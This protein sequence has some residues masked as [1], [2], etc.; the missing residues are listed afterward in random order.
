MSI[1]CS[2]RAIIT[3]SCLDYKK[4]CQLE[5][6]KYVHSLEEHRNGMTP[7]T[8]GAIALRP[9]GNAQGYMFFYSI[10]TGKRINRYKWMALP[11]PNHVVN[12]VEQLA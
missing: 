4:H 1:A 11:M 12:R 7:R 2:P 8:I 6:G 9:T 3:G 10:E 5:F